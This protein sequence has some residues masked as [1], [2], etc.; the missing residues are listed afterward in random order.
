M[1]DKLD[2]LVRFWE[3]RARH[4]EL[5][6]P[7]SA[8]EQREL[9]SLMQLVQG[10]HAP[11]PGSVPPPRASTVGARLLGPGLSESVTLSRV[12]ASAIVVRVDG[13]DA[14][15]LGASVV[16]HV[17]DAIRGVEYVLPCRVAWSQG[18]RDKTVALAVDG[19]PER[20]LFGG[21]GREGPT[22]AL[23]RI[24]ATRAPRLA[25]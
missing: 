14:P 10:D 18:A 12:S 20:A 7:L 4:A 11:R 6:E 1:L 2:F 5:G 22:R 21:P 17:T 15:Q 24:E 9:L 8:L 16:L 19:V 23:F 13:S 3:L 25:S